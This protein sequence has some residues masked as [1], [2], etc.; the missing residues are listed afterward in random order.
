VLS[1]TSP[2]EKPLKNPFRIPVR[3]L[4]NSTEGS[5]WNPKEFYLEPKRVQPGT[6]KGSPMGTAEEP[7][8]NPFFVRVYVKHTIPVCSC[9]K[10]SV[11]KLFI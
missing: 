8:W 10:I 2:K 9:P 3:T 5:T 11:F 6:K 1:R 4:L 7:I